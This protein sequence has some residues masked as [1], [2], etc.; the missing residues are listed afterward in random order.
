MSTIDADWFLSL[1]ESKNG[2]GPRKSITID[3]ESKSKWAGMWD[4]HTESGGSFGGRN[5]ALF[6]LVAF[7]RAKDWPFEGAV[8]YAKWWNQRYCEPPLPEDLIEN[9]V[10]RVWARW[11]AGDK[12]DLTPED[13][14]KKIEEKPARVLMTANDLLDLEASGKGMQWLVPNIFAVGSTHFLSAPAAGAKSWLM[15][16][17]SR[18]IAS[19]DDWLGQ[20]P[21]GQGAVLYIDEEMGEAKTS[22]RVKKLNFGRDTP[23]YYL[24]KQGIRINDPED[25]KFIIKTCVDYGVKLVCLDTL[26]GVRPGLQEN[27]GSH[28]S[29]LRAYFNAITDTGATLIVAHHDRKGGQGDSEV[30]HYR[31]A[32]SRDFGAM[33]DMA[34]GIEK[35]GTYF[36]LSVTK[37][38]LL[39]EEDE[40][41]IDFVLQDDDTHSRVTIRVI[42]SE[43]KNDRVLKMVEGRILDALKTGEMNT[44]TLQ[45]KVQG[46]KET[47][48]DAIKSLAMKAMVGSRKE[49]QA[50]IY[51]LE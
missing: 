34:Y 43:E 11:D 29:Q 6:K 38:R 32:G 14:Q 26:T 30:A 40:I 17:L 5:N 13:F 48:S 19:G 20:Y 31:M 18:C 44:R 22:G 51:F 49:G 24:G 8:S 7:M 12:P 21:V 15:L 46:K 50:T 35:Q 36:H 39:S 23:F 10:P 9:L 41:A 16:D 4:T 33:A 45:D 2:D 37:N 25:L 28:V 3:G 27:E 1:G 47:I 42:E